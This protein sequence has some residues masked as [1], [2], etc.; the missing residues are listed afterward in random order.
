MSA[1]S[2]PSAI[3]IVADGSAQKDKS[4]GLPTPEKI[5]IA[6][7]IAKFKKS[8]QQNN[9]PEMTTPVQRQAVPSSQEKVNI[10]ERISMFRKE[11]ESPTT[12]SNNT[13][14]KTVVLDTN[15]SISERILKLKREQQSNSQCASVNRVIPVLDGY[16]SDRVS[17]LMKE[18]EKNTP[19]THIHS[20][21]RLASTTEA[22]PALNLP[23]HEITPTTERES[24]NKLELLLERLTNKDPTLTVLEFN[25]SN[26]LAS[27]DENFELFAMVLKDNPYIVDME[28][29][30]VMMKDRHCIA[31]MGALKTCP[32]LMILNIET[33]MLTGAGVEAVAAM[34][35]KHPSL[36][37]LRIDNQRMAVGIEAERAIAN[38]LS[39]NTNIIRLS[40]TFR[41]TFVFTYVNKYLQRNLDIIRQIRMGKEMS[42]EPTPYPYPHV[43]QESDAAFLSPDMRE[44][45]AGTIF[46]EETLSVAKR[47]TILR[48]DSRIAG[49]ETDTPL[50]WSPRSQKAKDNSSPGLSP[51]QIQLDLATER[52]NEVEQETEV[53]CHF[54]TIEL[55]SP[56]S[57][58]D[59]IKTTALLS[60][61]T[62]QQAVSMEDKVDDVTL[63]ESIRDVAK[64]VESTEETK[65][66]G[67][68][69]D[70]E[71]GET[72]DA[73]G[74]LSKEIGYSNDGVK[75][76]AE[77][78]LNITDSIEGTG[79]LH[80]M[81]GL[82]TKKDTDRANTEAEILSLS[83]SEINAADISS[84]SQ[85]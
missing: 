57:D 2:S 27:K 12:H 79:N 40:Y 6:D 60:L 41:E 18:A 43:L 48:Q 4:D 54:E 70:I 84:S 77:V 28:L 20:A 42:T 62:S 15:L 47:I 83:S 51:A 29:C 1:T 24:K 64:P 46:E 33:N 58:L 69:S 82:A 8:A 9:S 21:T 25:N 30:N 32:N 53:D 23:E 17:M 56:S 80:V 81:N 13:T 71:K 45:I 72:A 16:V 10:S 78:S 38:C 63:K 44:K 59:D 61:V 3:E 55:T 31:L 37:E 66:I 39:Q 5:S 22:P 7:R 35:E 19:S 34:A 14:P 68:S 74:F 52:L 73:S 50:P 75:T 36:R 85:L 76:E 11:L 26:L 49:I 67:T 65:E